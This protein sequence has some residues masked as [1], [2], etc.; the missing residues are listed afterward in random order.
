MNKDKAHLAS[1]LLLETDWKD[2]FFTQYSYKID[3]F[4]IIAYLGYDIEPPMSKHQRTQTAAIALY[5]SNLDDDVKKVIIQKLLAAY[6]ETD[7]ASL[8]D[9]K[10][11]FSQTE[12]TSIGFTP[13]KVIKQ[14][15]GSKEKYFALLNEL[16]NKLYE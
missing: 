13:M 7:F 1:E 2:N 16:E 3:E 4:D 11:I 5:L 15:F 14:V 6:V 12:F 9:I 10:S 8:R